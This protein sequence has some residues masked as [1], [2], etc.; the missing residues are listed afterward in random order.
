LIFNSVT[1]KIPLKGD[2]EFCAIVVLPA[3]FNGLE[4]F[5]PSINDAGYLILW[6]FKRYC[7]TNIA[8]IL[9]KATMTINV[10][11]YP[12]WLKSLPAKAFILH[13][14]LINNKN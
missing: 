13:K 1:K 11:D 5:S 9:V 6:R 14:L 3:P 7:L 10:Q 4:N 2:N 8:A 12:H